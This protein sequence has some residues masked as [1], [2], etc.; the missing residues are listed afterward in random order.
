MSPNTGANRLSAA[1]TGVIGPVTPNHPRQDPTALA[2]SHVRRPALF[3]TTSKVCL[4]PH[5]VNHTILSVSDYQN[6]SGKELCEKKI[7]GRSF[8]S[9]GK[10]YN[11]KEFDVNSLT[12]ESA[13]TEN[14]PE[15]KEQ[16]CLARKIHGEISD[17]KRGRAE[18]SYGNGSDI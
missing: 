17:S 16:K 10:I 18:N 14:L 8:N 12:V 7:K 11:S 3:C 15:K 9:N 4:D 1:L 2:N 6:S 13:T 5:F